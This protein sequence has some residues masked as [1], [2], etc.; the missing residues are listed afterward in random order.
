MI[1]N[2]YNESNRVSKLADPIRKTCQGEIDKVFETYKVEQD[3]PKLG[4]TLVDIVKKY[5]IVL[6]RLEYNSILKA[7]SVEV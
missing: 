4:N 5:D 3:I 2:V 7:A 1:Y 6:K